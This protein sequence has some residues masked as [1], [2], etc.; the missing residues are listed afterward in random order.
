MIGYPTTGLDLGD[1][2]RSPR[3]VLLAIS[4]LTL[5]VLVGLAPTWLVRRR[6]SRGNQAGSRLTANSASDSEAAR[7]GESVTA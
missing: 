1:R 3:T 4:A 5:A 6:R 2:H 7:D